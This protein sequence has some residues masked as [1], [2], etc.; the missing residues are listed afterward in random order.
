MKNMR[1]KYGSLAT[2]CLLLLALLPASCIQDE[3]AAKEKATLT[4]YFTTTK[5]GD[6]TS[7]DATTVGPELPNEHMRTLRVIIADKNGK[8]RYNTKVNVP[9]E[10]TETILSFSELIVDADGQTNFDVYAIANEEVFNTNNEWE[11]VG[12]ELTSLK[13]KVLYSDVLDKLNE[14]I[15]KNDYESGYALPQTAIQE[16]SVIP[17]K[18][19][20]AKISL[21]FVVAK[22]R[23][24]IENTSTEAQTVS[25]ISLSGVDMTSTPLFAE[26]SLSNE[27]SGSV[28]LGN[29]ANIPAGESRMVYAYFYENIG[30]EYMLTADWHGSQT[31][32]F[33]SDTRY[34]IGSISRGT[35]LDINVT[36]SANT[37]PT[38]DILVVPWEEKSMEVT[39][40]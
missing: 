23:L 1:V 36:L 11:G 20:S 30:G 22:V 39:F 38:I 27:N 5:S 13:N 33:G 15:G 17:G 3:Y 2:L 28:F 10:Q 19:N 29:M 18:D 35:E 6:G 9:Q 32:S 24:K 8:I 37:K 31:L 26:T 7:S 21:D 12:I 14:G 4:L 34:N 16:V 25:G 40:D